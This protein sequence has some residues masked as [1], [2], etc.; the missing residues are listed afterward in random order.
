MAPISNRVCD[1][2]VR[3]EQAAYDLLQVKTRID[4]LEIIVNNMKAML[5]EIT[6]K[7]DEEYDIHIEDLI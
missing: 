6:R 1:L 4:Y 3:A 2:E 5:E 7:L